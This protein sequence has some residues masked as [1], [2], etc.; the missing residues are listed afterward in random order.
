MDRYCRHRLVSVKTQRFPQPRFEILST[1]M[2]FVYP[3][4]AKMQQRRDKAH[5]A[6]VQH[7][8]SA[9]LDPH[10]KKSSQ[11]HLLRQQSYI[12]GSLPDRYK[13]YAAW[14]AQSESPAALQ[15]CLCAMPP[16]P[17]AKSSLHPW[18]LYQIL[19]LAQGI[20]RRS[21]Q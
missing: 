18:Q 21:G 20:K 19:E 3:V 14:K 12:Q 2:V 6:S 13:E 4:E 15:P 9:C 1:L 11:I 7:W 8:H 16:R 10:N 17:K 5:R